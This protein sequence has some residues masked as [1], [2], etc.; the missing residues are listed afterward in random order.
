METMFE[1]MARTPAAWLS[2][3]GRESLVVL[4]SR[5]RLARNVAGCQFPGSADSATR[6]RIVNY[7]DSTRARSKLLSEGLYYKATDLSKLDQDFLVERHLISPG[8]LNGESSKALYIDPQ[9]RLSVMVNEEDHLRIQALSPG[10]DPEGAYKLATT[11]DAEISGHLEYAYDPDFG[12][13]TACP[14]NVGTGMRASV[15]IHLPG[16]VLTREIDKVI[17]HIT[18]S[19][20]VVR[21]FY[22]EGSDVL[23][24]LFQL[25]NQTTLGVS[26][27]ETLRQINRVA[28]EIIENEAGARQRLVNEAADMIEDKIWRAYGILKHARVLTSEEVMNLLSAVRLGHAMK[29][30]DFLDVA[31]VNEILLLSQP[32]HLQKYYGREMDATRR[33]FVRAQ[34]V[35]EKLRKFEN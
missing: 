31:L 20:L 27:D 16:L 21:G 9:E 25:S 3:K 28:D 10:L 22:G 33:D 12:Y 6:D 8:F 13:L 19:G 24:N 4:S 17:S 11:Y 34:M 32:S 23:G 35:R 5:V 26:E 29:I 15:L 30:I 2:G 1:E 18:R 7:F 14:T